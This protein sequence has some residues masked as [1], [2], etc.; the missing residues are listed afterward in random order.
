MTY[1]DV[2]FLVDDLNLVIQD[3]EPKTEDVNLAGPDATGAPEDNGTGD[4]FA[5][6]TDAADAPDG[7]GSVSIVINP[8]QQPGVAL[9][10]S[11]TFSDGKTG[12]WQLDSYGELGFIPPHANY[13]PTAPDVQQFQLL[14]KQELAKLGY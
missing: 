2:R 14:L 12:Q 7:T 9:G 8:V 5:D 6:G 11:V 10:G 3:K 1:M 4:A 13:Q